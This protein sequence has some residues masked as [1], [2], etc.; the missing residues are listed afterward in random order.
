MKPKRLGIQF[1]KK[2]TITGIK[3][4]TNEGV[5]DFETRSVIS[6]HREDLRRMPKCG[7]NTW[8]RVGTW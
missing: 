1:D 5:M 3:I 7:R 4:Q 6:P 8:A 2:Q